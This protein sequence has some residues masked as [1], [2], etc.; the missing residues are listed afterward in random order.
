MFTKAFTPHVIIFVVP[1]HNNCPEVSTQSIWNIFDTKGYIVQYKILSSQVHQMCNYKRSIVIVAANDG[2][3]LPQIQKQL[4]HTCDLNPSSAVGVQQ[5]ATKLILPI[6]VQVW[7]KII[8]LICHH[9]VSHWSDAGAEGKLSANVYHIKPSPKNK[10]WIAEYKQDKDLSLLYNHFSIKNTAIAPDIINNVDRCYMMHLREDRV[11]FL[12][13]KLVCH[14][15]VGGENR[16]VCVLLVPNALRRILFEA[17]HASGTGGHLGINKTLIVLRLR[18]LW[19]KMR[20][21][22]IAWVKVCLTCVQLRCNTRV[23]QQLVHS[24]PL[25]APFAIIS[26]DIWCP[27]D[28]VSPTGM[29]YVLNCMCD[30]TQF[31]VSTAI[32]HATAAELSRAFMENVL[33]KMGICIVLVVDDGNEFMGIFEQ[34][35]KGLKIRL[36]KAA[37]R[38]HKAVG[39][40]R[41]HRFLNHSVTILSNERQTIKCFVEAAMISAFAWN[42]MPTDGTD[43][44]RSVSAIG[45]PLQFPMDIAMAEI[46]D[47][48][49]DAGR[50]TVRYMRNISHDARFA[51]DIVLWL[52]EERRERHRERVNDS[53]CIISYEVGDMVMARVQV[54]SNAKTG[55]VG[56]LSIESRGPFRVVTNHGNGSYTVK[57]FDKPNGAERKFLAQDMYALPPTILP[58]DQIDLPDLR[59]MNTDFAPVAHPFKD[60]FNIESYN[61]IWFDKQPPL[62]KPTL[63][64]VCGANL[65][66]AVESPVNIQDISVARPDTVEEMDASLT[67]GLSTA[68]QAGAMV[69]ESPLVKPVSE[70][71]AQLFSNIQASKDK[72][73]F[74]AYRGANTIK[75][76]WYLVQIEL[77][78]NSTSQTTGMYFV[79]FFRS[80]PS[81]S[82][83]P[84]DCA[85]YWPD[86]YE[87]KYTDSTRTVF[88]FGQAVLVRPSRSPNKD[89]HCRFSDSVCLSDPHILLVGPFDFKPRS[90]D[91]PASQIVPWEQWDKLSLA[92]HAAGI[93]S[94]KLAND[95]VLATH[96]VAVA[97]VSRNETKW[98]HSSIQFTCKVLD[99]VN[100]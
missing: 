81:D 68:S 25:L 28:T 47:P 45:R 52:T 27:G 86:W 100:R 20:A 44:G 4:L 32:S 82:H 66:P 69:T 18:F 90:H 39:V 72:L 21:Q 17:Y 49:D 95:P 78:D 13:G 54:N 29:K 16:F 85:R 14:I 53:R 58:C 35:A 70:T 2:F 61:S 57:P 74:I 64:E 15:P 36:H 10:N 96:T 41:Y 5:E 59:Y 60:A 92:C 34:M 43:I 73:C 76:K 91:T 40:E 46:P 11:R 50:A 80:H 33:L 24:W 38:N 87:V 88:D 62:T 42:A 9:I 22:I 26:A 93:V 1:M 7:A 65:P 94:P 71:A 48:I 75:P 56:K 97:T 67:E 6:A 51:K 19:P 89:T 99:F 30:M 79:K 31:V 37:K 77:D 84:H 83:K 8:E 3:H 23:N 12:G 55:V 63:Q 98:Y